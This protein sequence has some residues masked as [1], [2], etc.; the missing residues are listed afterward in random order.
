MLKSLLLPVE[1]SGLYFQDYSVL[2]AERLH[3]SFA[4]KPIWGSSK[5][6]KL[7]GF[8]NKNDLQKAKAPNSAQ[9]PELQQQRWE[10]GSSLGGLYCCRGC[11]WGSVRSWRSRGVTFTSA[12]LLSQGLLR[13]RCLGIKHEF[14]QGFGSAAGVFAWEPVF[15]LPTKRSLAPERPAPAL[16]S[17][18]SERL[19]F[20]SP[21]LRSRLLG[22]SLP[23]I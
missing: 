16:L 19:D 12:P 7:K 21:S 18:Q 17:T 23:S 5:T 8:P 3:I 13:L 6:E 15:I 10:R 14:P 9:E 2:N 20:S 22:H 11:G 1:T 4:G